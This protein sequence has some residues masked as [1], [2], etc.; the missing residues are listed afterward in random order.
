M[1]TTRNG[2]GGSGPAGA[3]D[4]WRG[5]AA[6]AALFGGVLAVLLLGAVL[7]KERGPSGRSGPVP[8][9]LADPAMPPAAE[10]ALAAEPAGRGFDRLAARV[11]AD[12]DRLAGPG[13]AWT[14][15][16]AVLCDVARAEDLLDRFGSDSSLHLLPA[17]VGEEA[18]VRVCWS[19]YESGEA[20]RSAADL[21]QALRALQQQPLPKRVAEVLE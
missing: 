21:P 7:R 19:R 5:T 14:A 2:G 17:F 18:C 13:P 16:V 9:A 12:S 15:Q 20:A 3:P 8:A 10:P 4:G 11:L 6:F 1:P